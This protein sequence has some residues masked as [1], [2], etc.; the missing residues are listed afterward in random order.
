MYIQ[1]VLVP[2]VFIILVQS[3][4]W[5]EIPYEVMGLLDVRALLESQAIVLSESEDPWRLPE[6]F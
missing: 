4:I 3:R 6:V 1:S 5:I 2:T